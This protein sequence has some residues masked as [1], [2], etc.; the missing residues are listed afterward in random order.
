MTTESKM[1]KPSVRKELEKLLEPLTCEEL[2]EVAEKLEVMK[3]RI[4]ETVSFK[5]R[6]GVIETGKVIGLSGRSIKVDVNGTQWSVPASQ[7]RKV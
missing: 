1:L 5:G 6:Y 7:L 2:N 4:G 3:F